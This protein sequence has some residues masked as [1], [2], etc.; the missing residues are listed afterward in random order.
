MGWISRLSGFSLVVL[1]AGF[2]LGCGQKGPLERPQSGL[3]A[4][5]SG[6]AASEARG[7]TD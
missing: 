3:S 6:V 7:V 1:F 4:D 2:I 5:A